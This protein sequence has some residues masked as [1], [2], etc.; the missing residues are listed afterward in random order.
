MRCEGAVRIPDP[1]AGRFGT[2]HRRRR[3]LRS[4][5]RC[6]AVRR[7]REHD[8]TDRKATDRPPAAAHQRPRIRR[9]RG[10]SIPRNHRKDEGT[11]ARHSPQGNSRQI[12]RDD[13]RGPADRRRRRR[14]RPLRQGRGGRRHR[15]DHHLQFR[16]LPHGGARLGRRAAR[17]WQRQRDRQGDGRRGAAGR[18]EHAGA[19]RRQRHRSLRADAALPGRTEGDGLFGRPELPDH[20]PVRRQDA[21]E[22]R[23]DRHG[24]TRSRS[25]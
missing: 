19:G 10:R 23:G 2:R 13:R 3:F 7:A 4:G 12:P 17:L 11:D 24:L 20:R 18:E 1:G 5:G 16:P 22:L 21:A 14:H 8:A 6:R 25:T 9:G 15:P